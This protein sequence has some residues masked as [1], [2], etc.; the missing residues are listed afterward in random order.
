MDKRSYVFSAFETGAICI[1]PTEAAARS[2]LVDYALYSGRGA[3]LRDRAISFDTFGSQFLAHSA[4]LE[5]SNAL[6][7]QLFV[8]RLIEEGVE[9][10]RL[11]NP[12]YPQSYRRLERTIAALL[13]SLEYVVGDEELLARLDGPLKSDL[14]LLYGEYRRFLSAHQ[15]FEGRYERSSLPPNWNNRV[16]YIIL[17]SDTIARAVP[18]LEEL[19]WPPNIELLPTPDVELA[20]LA[21]YP[22]HIQEI[23]STLRA[24]ASLLEQGVES[25]AITIGCAASDTLVPILS[26]EAA[27]Y[28]IP[29]SIREGGSPLDYPGGRFLLRL[30][31]VYDDSFSLESLKSLLLDPS[32]PWLDTQVAHRFIRR[33][34][35]KSIFEGSIHQS[36]QF[37]DRLHEG[38]LVSWYRAFKESIVA[39]V[40]AT[41]VPELRRK[42]NHFQ[43]T[44][45]IE[46]QWRGSAGEEVY[47]FCLDAIAEIERAMGR[48]NTTAYTRLFSW[49]IT[50][51]RTKRYVFQGQGSGVAVYAWPQVATLNSQ[52]LFVIGLDQEGGAVVERPLFFL[53]EEEE[54]SQRDTTV[55][56]LRSACLPIASVTLSCHLRRYEGETL[57]PAPFFEAGRLQYLTKAARLE[58]DPYHA[59]L[60]LWRGERREGVRSLPSQRRRFS[61]ALQTTLR[62]RTDDYTRHPIH[63]SLVV[64]L[65]EEHDGVALLALSATKIDLFDRC[66]YA[67]L[68]RYLL[69][70]DEVE[71]ESSLVDH[72]L[73]GTV[74]HL[75]FQRFFNTIKVFESHKDTEYRTMLLSLFDEAMVAVYGQKGPTPSI[76][77][78]IIGEHRLLLLDIL[79]EERRLFDGMHSIAIEEKCAHTEGGMYLN[80]RID[81]IV[82]C[83]PGRLGVI[84]YKKGKPP[85]KKIDERPKSYQL[86][87]YQRLIEAK[88]D[89]ACTIAA[90]Y[91]VK[92]GKYFTLWEGEGSEE[93]DLARDVLT[94][95]L[96]TLLE[97]V[98]DGR[99]MA[100]PSQT[101]C[102][103]CMY[104]PL[105]RRRYATP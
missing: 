96:A 50:T 72:R 15:L 54:H 70:I 84:D 65:K 87:L 97:A 92:E 5:P 48:T 44:Y 41:N 100:T 19:G 90:Y 89:Q 8:H 79:G 51:L 17:Y 26:E 4:A 66:P 81:R 61:N 2:A 93:A 76:R 53:P 33:A 104:R 91:S 59:E 18:L 32:V 74:E 77:A 37:I 45:F 75:V 36:D 69:K 3:I 46:T 20:T 47:S 9:L 52:H 24:I 6:I 64:R 80:G 34:I 13:P 78:W 99:L 42:L 71:W 67:F 98:D 10:L 16:R 95:R 27:H 39:V 85:M 14:L 55:A 58:S 101:S 40:E 28:D 38:E 12:R 86:P 49:L 31:E 63:P 62:A 25:S 57:P 102:T 94:W 11:V 82:E 88:G 73:I 56:H 23:R 83:E 103:D 22:N 30:S 1:F 7:R 29:L 43:D 105:C 68:A 60:A 21:V 35:D